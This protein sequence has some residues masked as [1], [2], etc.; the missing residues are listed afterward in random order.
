MEFRGFVKVVNWDHCVEQVEGSNLWMS[1]TSQTFDDS[2]LLTVRRTLARLDSCPGTPK[3]FYVPFDLKPPNQIL[4][5]N[6]VHCS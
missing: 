3:S 6:S 2:T 5:P 1:P 4:N